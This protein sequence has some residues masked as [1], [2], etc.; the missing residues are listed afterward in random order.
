M[1]YNFY[2]LYACAI[3]GTVLIYTSCISPKD[4]VASRGMQNLTARYNI[5]YNA[6]ILLEESSENIEKAH[7]DNYG[8]LLSVYK[9]PSETI[10]A[11]EIKQLDSVINKANSI[12]NEKLHSNYV[13]EAYML[14]AKAN[15]LKS[16]FF[17]AAE[18]FSYLN[19]NYPDE[20][21]VRQ[22]SLAWKARALLQLQ[23]IEEAS[24]TIDTALKYI[25]ISP[26]HA[27]DV[28]AVSAQLAITQNQDLAAIEALKNALDKGSSKRKETRWK[29]IMAQLQ[30]ENKQYEE[31]YKNFSAVVKSNASFEMA[32]NANLNR[33]QIEEEQSGRNVD[34]ITRLESL[35]KDDKN[36]DFTDQI[37]YHIGN[38]HFANNRLDE[39]I[40]SY[41][42]SIRESS[43]NQNQKGLSYLKLADIYFNNAEYVRAKAYYDSTISTLSPTYPGYEL[44]R[45]KGS[46]L[47]LLASRYR[48]IAREDT[49]QQLA[50]LPE[51]QR[52][53]R[54]AELVRLQTDRSIAQVNQQ[55][56]PNNMVAGIDRPAA[57]T[58]TEGKFYFNNST[59]LGQGFSDFK[60]IWGNRR[61][62]DNWRRIAKTAAETTTSMS[63]D[64]DA[65]IGASVGSTTNSVSPQALRQDYL[66]N[67]PLT[68]PQLGQSNQRIAEAYY[69]IANFY[70]D[71]LRDVNLAINTFEQLLKRAPKSTYT[72]PVYYNLYRLYQPTD[73]DKSNTYRDLILSNF[74]DSPFA[75]AIRD[76]NYSR[77]ADEKEAALNNAYNRIFELY[78]QRKYA[79][80]L[81]AIQRVE[82]Q[83]GS[84]NLS[85][86][87]AYLNAL[88]VGHT[89]KLPP[90]EN[91]L[92][93]L[94]A[95]YPADQLIT[96]LAKQHLQ[97]IQE[98]RTQMAT[99]QTALLDFDPN[100]PSFVDEPAPEQTAPRT[101]ANPPT[102]APA[103]PPANVPETKGSTPASATPAPAVVPN[104]TAPVNSTASATKANS[105]FSLPGAAEYYFVVNVT[106][107]RYNLSSSR[108]GIGQF[109]RTRYA[110]TPLRHQLQEANNE[111]ELIY[112]GAFNTYE[113]AKTYES[114]ILPLLKDIMKIP[115]EHYT[116][117]VITKE[118]LEKLQ[119]RQMINLY[120]DFYKSSN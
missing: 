22:E 57:A 21:D 20:K 75:K 85:P 97:F 15:Y 120:I 9:E 118:S 25:A 95:T 107:T 7:I 59:A 17:I 69:D 49:L 84:S 6:N 10:S 38:I 37:Y 3:L 67:L 74:P 73:L 70:K 119:N 78:T 114:S 1:K 112:I 63:T 4:S 116:T 111:N 27:A 61:L 96:P 44:I 108:F 113:D 92:Q 52:E 68:E 81:P 109:N 54:I 8:Q 29:Y 62:E 46:N 19:T 33:I 93:Q 71:E 86:Q 79:E 13:D 105:M 76:P 42:T 28:Y 110:G 72:L 18:Y 65:A 66:S 117:F 80:V 5:I 47:E 88:A 55:V 53:E 51:A 11:S 30:A 98:N 35:L 89:Q 82:Q 106:D 34:R 103:T 87:L 39:A 32:F 16:Q 99:R 26:K 48:A 100:A 58:L 41:N 24:K 101:A 77:A 102:S 40:Q 43:A 94:V 50:A 60:R 12:V 14:I 91:V 45:K 64:P 83:F 31:A 2:P 23:N 90:F 104:T 115:A 36:Q 56:A